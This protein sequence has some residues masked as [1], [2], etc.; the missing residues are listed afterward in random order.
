MVVEDRPQ[1]GVGPV[2]HL[3]KLREPPTPG[4]GDE[5]E[6][7]SPVVG[8]GP[9]FDVPVGLEPVEVTD[10]RGGFDV[11]EVG[12]LALAGATGAR[13]LAEQH[14]VP[15][16]GALGLEPLVEDVV[17]GPMPEV[18]AATERWLHA[19]IVS[20]LMIRRAS[21]SGTEPD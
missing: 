16:A 3:V 2:G 18:E 21:T 19:L 7:P 15:E 14:P 5:H 10:E 1:V 13:G 9:A 12:E 4:R 8:V 6:Q 20:R 11:H 17:H